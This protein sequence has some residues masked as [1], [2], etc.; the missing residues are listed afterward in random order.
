MVSR[1]IRSSIPLPTIE[2]EENFLIIRIP[3]DLDAIE[4][5]KKYVFPMLKTWFSDLEKELQN[6]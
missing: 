2:V 1:M 5:A 3:L 4:F 6:K